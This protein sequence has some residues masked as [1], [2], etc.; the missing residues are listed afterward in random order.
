MKQVELFYCYNLELHRY[1]T[2][3]GIRYITKAKHHKTNKL[4]TLYQQTEELTE[5]LHSYKGNK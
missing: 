3:Q 4:F 5:A 1:L 2:Q